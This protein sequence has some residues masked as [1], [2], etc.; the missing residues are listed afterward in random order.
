MKHD[1][2]V[3]MET[4]W[5]RWALLVSLL[6]GALTVQA[7]KRPGK[8]N[9]SLAERAAENVRRDA[10]S[11]PVALHAEDYFE[12]WARATGEAQPQHSAWRK[13]QNQP[14]ILHGRVARVGVLMGRTEVALRGP[15]PDD[16]TVC[17]LQPGQSPPREGRQTSLQ[18]F[19]DGWLVGPALRDCVVVSEP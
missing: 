15:T 7:C 8:R 12:E 1:E 18:G 5:V 17:A 13:Y 6:A 4:R 14:V 10:P 11:E 2:A 16:E 19:G 3:R 9:T